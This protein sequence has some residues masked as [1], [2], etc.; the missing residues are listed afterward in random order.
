M[1]RVFSRNVTHVVRWFLDEC[2]PPVLRDRR[3]LLFP[4]FHL[5]YRGKNVRRYME[6]KRTAFSLTEEEFALAYSE[7]DSIGTERPT[8]MNKESLAKVLTLLPSGAQS[9][10]DVGC[11]RGYFLDVVARE[12]PDLELTGLDVLPDVTLAGARYVSGTAERLPFEDKSFDV[13][14]SS[15]TIEHVRDLEAMVSELTRV[16]RH[17]IIVVTPRQR[18]YRYTFDM[19]LNFF[20]FDYDLPRLFRAPRHDQWLLRGDWVYVAHLD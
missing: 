16:A 2:L 13:V 6:F 1:T 11:G 12:R 19:H 15:H 3:W 17:Q 10:L 5:A 9:L 8:D 20:W 14:F 18:P 7:M 4:L